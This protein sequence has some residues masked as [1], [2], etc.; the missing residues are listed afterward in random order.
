MS[1]PAHMTKYWDDL[2]D[3]EECPWCGEMYLPPRCDCGA[4]EEWRDELDR[5]EAKDDSYI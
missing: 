5:D 2:A 4:A 3:Q 1:Y